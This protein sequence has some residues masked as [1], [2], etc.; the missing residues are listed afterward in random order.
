VSFVTVFVL[1]IYLFIDYVI[2]TLLY[3]FSPLVGE[4]EGLVTPGVDLALEGREFLVGRLDLLRAAL[5]E[6]GRGAGELLLGGAGVA[7]A[8]LLDVDLP[9]LELALGPVDA[10][11]MEAVG[12]VNDHSVDCFRRDQM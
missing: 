10:Q 5:L 6:L 3:S 8:L 4:L 2:S 7:L 9:L 11:P 1:F 12:V